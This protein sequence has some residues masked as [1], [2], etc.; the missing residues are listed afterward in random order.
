MVE[1]AHLDARTDAGS[2]PVWSTKP[3]APWRAETLRRATAGASPVRTKTAEMTGS[4]L[5]TL[6]RCK[7]GLVR[8]AGSGTEITHQGES[9]EVPRLPLQP[10]VPRERT[11]TL[12]SPDDGCRHCGTIDGTHMTNC[13]SLRGQP[14]ERGAHP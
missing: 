1:R 3:A 13:P 4:R 14:T 8:K 5:A 2:I 11:T 7:S 12:L 10:Q 9:P 6:D